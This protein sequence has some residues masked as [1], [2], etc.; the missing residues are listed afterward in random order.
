M[1]G[2]DSLTSWTMDKPDEPWRRWHRLR[3]YNEIRRQS[4]PRL[5]RLI[6]LFRDNRFF[7]ATGRVS[8]YA[9][10]DLRLFENIEE[11]LEFLESIRY[12]L[13]I[14]TPRRL[15]IYDVKRRNDPYRP[16]GKPRRIGRYVSFDKIERIDPAGAL[17]LAAEF[18]RARR[19]FRARLPAVNVEKWNADVRQT[20]TGLGF[21]SLLEIGDRPQA[22]SLRDQSGVW[23]VTPFISYSHVE[24]TLTGSSLRELAAA[25]GFDEHSFFADVRLKHLFRSV[26]DSMDN[27]LSHAY[28]NL[29][30]GHAIFPHVGRWWL[31]G[32][33]DFENRRLSVS[34]FDQGITI[35]GRLIMDQDRT[36][37]SAKTALKRIIRRGAADCDLVEFAVENQVTTTGDEQRGRGLGKLV[38]FV[39]ACQHGELRIVSRQGMY[40]YVKGLSA[41]KCDLNCSVGGTLISW[42]VEL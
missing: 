18:D 42:Q 24:S 3:T 33:V 2:A 13:K 39:D 40:H 28:L 6:S 22:L 41:T 1:I 31:T 11:V 21:F 19:R 34:L 16:A 15:R 8:R 29:V 32:A 20:L 38:E 27:V 10:I 23:R 7:P 4:G 26:I 36:N 25:L 37:A 35:P 17:L 5:D 9:P 14:T 12:S 30:D